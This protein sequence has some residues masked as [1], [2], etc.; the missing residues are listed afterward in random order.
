MTHIL[1]VYGVHKHLGLVTMRCT[2]PMMH[3]SNF[4]VHFDENGRVASV[5]NPHVWPRP[6]LRARV[7]RLAVEA[8]TAA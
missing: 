8:W 6:S 7:E 1:K 5:V 3:V 4:T 2:G